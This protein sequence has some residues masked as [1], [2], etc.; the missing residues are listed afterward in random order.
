MLLVLDSILFAFVT[1]I[2]RHIEPEGMIENAHTQTGQDDE[3]AR[4]TCTV[5]YKTDQYQ[6]FSHLYYDPIK[7]P[8][9]RSSD[10][11]IYS[12]S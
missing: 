7:K 2:V 11:L 6:I 3:Q 9:E 1:V 4:D 10:R 5:I 12:A 8:V